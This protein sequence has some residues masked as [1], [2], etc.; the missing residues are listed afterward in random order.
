MKESTKSTQKIIEETLYENK[1]S[2]RKFLLGKSGIG[3]I[4]EKVI[5]KLNENEKDYEYDKVLK[6]VTKS[7][8]TPRIFI[9]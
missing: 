9:K 4:M 3:T 6:K 5:E 1:E 2:L 8:R 7:M